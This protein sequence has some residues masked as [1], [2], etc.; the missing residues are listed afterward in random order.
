MDWHLL[1]RR[2]RQLRSATLKMAAAQ[3]RPKWPVTGEWAVTTSITVAPPH[4][5]ARANERLAGAGLRRRGG[6]GCPS[7]SLREAGVASE[8]F[9][10]ASAFS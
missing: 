7:N 6:G 9:F 2:T 10:G 8:V 1:P 4:G 5:I 3:P